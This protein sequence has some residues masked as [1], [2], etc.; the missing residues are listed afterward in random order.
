VELGTLS[1]DR[2]A[3]KELRKSLGLDDIISV[4]QQNKL[5]WYGYV[6]QKEDNN[7]MKKCMEYEVESAKRRGRPKRTCRE[8]V[9][10]LSSVYIEQRMLQIIVNGGR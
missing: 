6:L 2:V 8:V 1:F 10:R 9:Q 4:V 3:S 5:R 7:W